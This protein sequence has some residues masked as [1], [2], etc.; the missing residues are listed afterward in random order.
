MPLEIAKLVE[1]DDL[2][3]EELLES[4][5]ER[6]KKF[7]IRAIQ[8]KRLI[9]ARVRTYLQKVFGSFYTTEKNEPMVLIAQ[10][11]VRLKQNPHLKGRDDKIK[12]L[13]NLM[14]NLKENGLLKLRLGQSEE[15]DFTIISQRLTVDVDGTGEK[16]Y[17]ITRR[18]PSPR[19]AEEEEK[20]R[21]ATY[22]EELKLIENVKLT[23][24]QIDG[25]INQPIADEI[26]AQATTA[27]RNYFQDLET[28][29]DN[30]LHILT[31]IGFIDDEFISELKLESLDLAEE[32]KGKSVIDK[33]I[34]LSALN[35]YR[36]QWASRSFNEPDNLVYFL[37]GRMIFRHAPWNPKGDNEVREALKTLEINCAELEKA[38][39]QQ[40]SDRHDDDTPSS[41]KVDRKKEKIISLISQLVALNSMLA[42]RKSVESGNTLLKKFLR[43]GIRTEVSRRNMVVIGEEIQSKVKMDC[44]GKLIREMVFDKKI[45]QF[46]GWLRQ[47]MG[48][49]SLE[50]FQQLQ[51]F[52]V[53]HGLNNL[54]D[55]KERERLSAFISPMDIVQF[56]THLANDAVSIKDCSSE[57]ID[58]VARGST[59]EALETSQRTL[60]NKGVTYDKAASLINREFENLLLNYEKDDFEN[61]CADC[62]PN[63]SRDQDPHIKVKNYSWVAR[64]FPF[65]K[66]YF[67]A[68][69]L[70]VSPI[71]YNIR[72][73][74]KEKE[75]KTIH[76]KTV[77]FMNKV[78]ELQNYLVGQI[79]ASVERFN[80]SALDKNRLESQLVSD[81]EIDGVSGA[82]GDSGDSNY[83]R[84]LEEG[85]R[86]VFPKLSFELQV[87]VQEQG[88]ELPDEDGESGGGSDDGRALSN[89][90]RAFEEKY[91]HLMT[92]DH[93]PAEEEK[94]AP[95]TT[96]RISPRSVQRL[97][98][99]I[100]NLSIFFDALKAEGYEKRIP[101]MRRDQIVM[102]VRDGCYYIRD[103]SRNLDPEKQD[104]ARLLKKSEELLEKTRT[105]IQRVEVIEED[106]NVEEENVEVPL[107]EIHSILVTL[108][109]SFMVQL[110]GLVDLI[111]Q[112]HRS[113][114]GSLIK[115]EQ[116]DGTKKFVHHI[117]SAIN[118]LIRNSRNIKLESPKIPMAL[119]DVMS[120]NI[121]AAIGEINRLK[122]SQLI[123]QS[124][125][126]PNDLKIYLN[127]V[128][129]Y[130]LE[131]KLT[132][133]LQNINTTLKKT[134]TF[135]ND[136]QYAI[137]KADGEEQMSSSIF[138]QMDVPKIAIANVPNVLHTVISIGDSI[139]DHLV[140]RGHEFRQ[141]IAAQNQ[142]PPERTNFDDFSDR[143]SQ[144]VCG[145]L[146][147]LHAYFVPDS[148]NNITFDPENLENI[149]RVIGTCMGEL[150]A[151]T[152]EF[153]KNKAIFLNEIEAVRKIAPVLEGIRDSVNDYNANYLKQ[154]K[155]ADL[156]RSQTNCDKTLI[157]FCQELTKYDDPTT[158][159]YKL[160]LIRGRIYLALE[161]LVQVILGQMKS[162]FVAEKKKKYQ[163]TVNEIFYMM[164][165]AKT[166][167]RDFPLFKKFMASTLRVA[168]GC[169][170][171]K[172]AAEVAGVVEKG[173]E[174]ED[175]IKVAG[176]GFEE[177]TINQCFTPGMDVTRLR[178]LSE[179]I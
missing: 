166:E 134:Q 113:N 130:I 40:A 129:R 70:L 10:S 154:K 173:E 54:A 52:R 174:V 149:L 73:G 153:N 71:M 139:S 36:N 148:N 13:S 34:F 45:K 48:E 84:L 177:A 171:E 165:H 6:T 119:R 115:T 15:R 56:M 27:F 74:E 63:Y 91:A 145:T 39:V 126:H 60:T 118:T 150:I 141:K 95:T 99:S 89:E 24:K 47:A 86:E 37:I 69:A 26:K 19:K 170:N 30:A 68:C 11:L 78:L 44:L 23:C 51:A 159:E 41:I 25:L 17:E 143:M 61:R 62:N 169:G 102:N 35:W 168:K 4:L 67:G 80:V 128:A 116:I 131:K 16:S 138:G 104:T 77:E 66:M 64:H 49:G 58:I 83:S 98:K 136:K 133:P 164:S 82:G 101:V 167:T 122:R 100:E 72:E 7:E 5:I 155:S 50:L 152:R 109:S 97:S 1:D 33:M 179:S 42:R 32:M 158:P 92:D 144:H 135:V 14:D 110:T 107:Y 3:G 57:K 112:K 132:V 137:W 111:A 120:V 163:Q 142:P 46:V 31:G 18:I 147:Q 124:C 103:I 140:Q 59:G 9:F 161:N 96:S 108:S 65:L 28:K 125:Q 105:S 146:G 55:G 156:A 85:V 160:L 76:E 121:N 43:P 22:K 172:I 87:L 2:S 127:Q 106:I 75:E 8:D 21:L 114:R 38:F 94:P 12:Q 53:A 151:L 176:G 29:L 20:K 123:I 93:G 81:K 175:W 88:D 90:E 162:E 178:K 79:E 157:G 117:D